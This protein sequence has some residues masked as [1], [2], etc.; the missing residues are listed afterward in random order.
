MTTLVSGASGM[1]GKFGSTA[2]K[3][4]VSVGKAKV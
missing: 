1:Y 3:A 4:K 2:S